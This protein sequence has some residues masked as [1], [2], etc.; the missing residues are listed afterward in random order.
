ME[1]EEIQ[2]APWIDK[3]KAAHT[4]TGHFEPKLD[5]AKGTWRS[6]PIE[7]AIQVAKKIDPFLLSLNIPVPTLIPA[8]TA[9]TLYNLLTEFKEFEGL[10]M[11]YAKVGGYGT[12]SGGSTH[13]YRLIDGKHCIKGTYVSGEDTPYWRVYEKELF[14]KEFCTPEQKTFIDYV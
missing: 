10:E 12:M 9:V 6:P 2:F 11:I 5:D 1:T 3:Y 4:F 14:A 13:K 7:T 8:S